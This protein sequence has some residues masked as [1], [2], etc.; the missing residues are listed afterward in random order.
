[1]VN[2]KKAI[3]DEVEKVERELARKRLDK[4]EK[5]RKERSRKYM[6][7]SISEYGNIE[8]CRI[9][10]RDFKLASDLMNCNIIN[11][12]LQFN[13]Y[14]D[15]L[16]VLGRILN[17]NPLFICVKFSSKNKGTDSFGYIK[18]DDR[19]NFVFHFNR[20]FFELLKL[21]GEY[22]Y[23]ANA[24]LWSVRNSVNSNNLVSNFLGRCFYYYIDLD[25]GCVFENIYHPSQSNLIGYISYLR[26]GCRLDR[27]AMI[28]VIAKYKSKPEDVLIRESP[29]NEFKSIYKS[30]VIRFESH[31]VIIKVFWTYH[32]VEYFIYNILT[33]SIERKVEEKDVFSL[34]AEISNNVI[35]HKKHNPAVSFDCFFMDC[36]D[37]NDAALCD[38]EN[39]YYSK[40]LMMDGGLSSITSLFNLNTHSDQINWLKLTN[41]FERLFCDIKFN[42]LPSSALSIASDYVLDDLTI[43]AINA[44]S[45]FFGYPNITTPPAFRR[46][47]KFTQHIPII[48]DPF[49][50]DERKFIAYL[51]G[52]L[53]L[54]VTN[55]LSE[56]LLFLSEAYRARLYPRWKEMLI[57]NFISVILVLFFLSASDW[58]YDKVSNQVESSG[59]NKSLMDIKVDTIVSY[60]D[61]EIFDDVFLSIVCNDKFSS[62]IPKKLISYEDICNLIEFLLNEYFIECKLNN[63]GYTWDDLF[64]GCV[65]SCDYVQSNKAQS[66][67]NQSKTKKT[68]KEDYDFCT[69]FED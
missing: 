36:R 26:D 65:V 38:G 56:E 55:E 35:M 41:E 60:C 30:E 9:I 13:S 57:I 28:D 6:P 45:L 27:N 32:E 20:E 12:V 67:E 47:S 7:H 5:Q 39:I 14:V 10:P 44:A 15:I 53:T 21:T 8:Q 1:M 64:E 31:I 62:M 42:L 68:S 23:R 48:C 58:F 54:A 61:P 46:G 3:Q 52:Y 16:N 59:A 69:I 34:S 22:H 18:D 17:V 66:E 50:C 19:F 4:E 2:I 40:S 63:N 29:L 51:S 49:S 24:E 25:C 43:N 11:G 37:F 33:Q